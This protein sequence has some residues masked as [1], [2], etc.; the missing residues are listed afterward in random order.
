[1]P[2]ASE[3]S[4]NSHPLRSVQPS[5]LGTYWLLAWCT[6]D[7]GISQ[8][9]DEEEKKKNSNIVTSWA[10]GPTKSATHGSQGIMAAGTGHTDAFTP[11][12]INT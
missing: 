12:D 7:H 10:Q 2:G 1:M 11:I 3:G 5:P 8:P 4:W 9:L 6:Q